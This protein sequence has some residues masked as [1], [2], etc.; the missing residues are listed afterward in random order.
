MCSYLKFMY[1]L[2]ICLY[3]NYISIYVCKYIYLFGKHKLRFYFNKS[4]GVT[5]MTI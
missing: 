5:M 2:L 1:L 4:Y 3:N